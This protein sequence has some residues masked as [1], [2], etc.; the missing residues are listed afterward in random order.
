MVCQ[1]IGSEHS[2]CV[3]VFLPI[4]SSNVARSPE[5]PPHVA[6]DSLHDSIIVSFE[7]RYSRVNASY[8]KS[9]TG[10]AHLVSI[11]PYIHYHR[12]GILM[13]AIISCKYVIMVFI[14]NAR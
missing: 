8:T 6:V 4:N 9:R 1:L 11:Y 14:E 10:F 3:F 12:G 7:H 2:T 5:N 13:T